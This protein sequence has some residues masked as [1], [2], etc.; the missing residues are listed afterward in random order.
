M[1]DS[2]ALRLTLVT[3]LGLV[4]LL[5]IG[6]C[7]S[8]RADT[9]FV[10]VA[11]TGANTGT[12]WDSAYTDL[13]NALASAQSGDEVWVAL[14]VYRPT[15]TSGG[16]PREAS[17]V[18]K[19]GVG[20]YGGFVGN[21]T[22]RSGRDPFANPTVLSGDLNADDGPGFSNTSDNAFRVVSAIGLG[23]QVVFD[24]FVIE[25][26]RADGAPAASIA[27]S[28]DSGAALA[29]DGGSLLLVRCII[30]RNWAAGSGAFAD[31]GSGSTLLGCVFAENHAELGGAGVLISQNAATQFD[32]CEFHQN[33][34]PADGAAILSVSEIGIRLDDC[35]FAA[36][37]A[38]RGGG[39]FFS[40]NATGLVSTCEFTDNSAYEGGGIAALASSPVIRS[41]FFMGN[42]A[43]LSGGGTFA[44]GG[45]PE[46]LDCIFIDNDAAEGLTGGLGGQGG[47]GGG[48][49]WYRGGAGRVENSCYAN[50]RASL[51]GG[52]YVIEGNTAVVRHCMF[53]DNRANEAAGLYSLNATPLI[54]DSLFAD[55]HA[56][57][58]SF[59]VGGAISN[60]F[61]SATIED[62]LFERNRAELGGGAIYNEGEAP[63]IRRCAFRQNDAYG[64]VAGWGGG[65]LN[66]FNTS[67]RIESCEFVS[68]TAQLG[69]AIAD[70]YNS[71]S[72]IV[73]CTLVSNRAVQQGGGV[74]AFSGSNATYTNGVL[75]GNL[76]QQISGYAP[77][78]VQ[79]SL[80]QGGHTGTGVFDAAPRFVRA[81]APG[82]DQ[83]WGTADDD[84]GDLRPARNSVLIDAGDS[85]A[86]ADP[87]GLDMGLYSRMRDDPASPDAGPSSLLGRGP[88][89]LGAH[90]FHGTSC[91]GDFDLDGTRAVPDIFAFLAAWFAGSPDADAN[92]SRALGV[93]DIF[94]YLA[95]WFAGCP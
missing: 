77:T 11:A 42:S 66:G 74:F 37:T 81:A 80:V 34:T 49:S 70:H 36:N 72:S 65:V 79:W 83:V 73:N 60:Y 27:A 88:V 43:G 93:D 6:L 39:V 29:I 75:V 67:S 90:E 10:N 18:L 95:A 86:L 52:L 40:P 59:A 22:S 64:E 23:E 76:P 61:G 5:S 51:G 33:T 50:N 82:D 87:S 13:A 14:G 9:W 54:Q 21:E 41:C 32:A 92:R 1:S 7:R 3:R 28:K 63:I 15:H 17:F 48:G 85:D 35:V 89:D 53:V 19:T 45:S 25:A 84:L 24:G 16:T 68:N 78:T 2:S 58:S 94:A 55:N 8:A 31:C 44:E 69:A 56:F 91:Q 20:M 12:G 57:G 46:I 62:C 38:Q 26:G 4:A 30:R 47:S 71:T